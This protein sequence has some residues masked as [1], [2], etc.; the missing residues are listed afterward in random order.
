MVAPRRRQKVAKRQAGGRS[1]K[2]AW[3]GSGGG[4][5]AARRQQGAS[6]KGS[7][8]QSSQSKHLNKITYAKDSRT[9][10]AKPSHGSQ[11]EHPKI[12]FKRSLHVVGVML[13]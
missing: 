8:S 1:Q 11:I 12:L 3:G 6:E 2:A 5:E 4:C 10:P 7:L 13:V 9:S